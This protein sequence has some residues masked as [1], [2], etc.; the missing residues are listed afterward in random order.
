MCKLTGI[1]NINETENYI[2][3]NSGLSS[4]NVN[5]MYFYLISYKILLLQ[6]TIIKHT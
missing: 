6:L 3:V 5:E 1:L 2:L 4:Q